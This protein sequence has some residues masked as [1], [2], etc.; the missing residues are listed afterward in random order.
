MSDVLVG[1]V[2][3]V[4]KLALLV[5]AVADT[6]RHN[7]DACSELRNIVDLLGAIVAPLEGLD[8]PMKPDMRAALTNLERAL[9][10]GHKLVADCQRERNFIYIL[11]M[12]RRQSRQLLKVKDDINRQMLIA[13]FAIN[14]NTHILVAVSHGRFPQSSIE[15]CTI[16]CIHPISNYT[17]SLYSSN[18]KSNYHHLFMS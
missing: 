10:Q 18:L 9:R 6:A 15:V 13:N 1:T 8:M 11:F 12:A 17:M 7:K 16:V 5:K 3:E 4:V 14:A 2:K